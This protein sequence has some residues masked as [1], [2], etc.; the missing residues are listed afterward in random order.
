VV[1]GWMT[2][3]FPEWESVTATVA[4]VAAAVGLLPFVVAARAE[5]RVGSRATPR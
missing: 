4:L 3:R 1:L 5:S 2:G